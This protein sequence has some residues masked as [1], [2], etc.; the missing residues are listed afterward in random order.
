LA[1]D[2]I[3]NDAYIYYGMALAYADEANYERAIAYYQK[4]IE[5]KPDFIE[6]HYNLG[7]A[8]AAKED[9]DKAIEIFQKIIE[10]KPD[11][12]NAYYSLGTIYY[13][14]DD[15]DKGIEFLQKFIELNPY[16]AGTPHTEGGIVWCLGSNIR[17]CNANVFGRCTMHK[18]FMPD[19]KSAYK[20]IGLAYEYKKDYDKMIENFKNILDLKIDS[21]GSTYRYLGNGYKNRKD[22]DNAIETYKKGIELNSDDGSL[23]SDLGYTYQAKKDYDSAI[24]TYKIIIEFCENRIESY[25]N[26]DL[27]TDYVKYQLAK[28][29]REISEV[30]EAKGDNGKALE[31][32]KKAE[33]L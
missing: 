5:F 4:I 30:Y 31:F 22:Y 15:Y 8:Y 16:Y 27:D 32:K 29:Y 9:Y 2:K 11:Y 18:N 21:S 14:N 7:I 3:A 1:T 17:N 10:R 13:K 28:A 19:H 25:E 33:E 23:Y 6:V 12:A 20:N 24:E 26:N